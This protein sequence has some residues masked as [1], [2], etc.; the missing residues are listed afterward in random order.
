M[1]RSILVLALFFL[2]FSSRAQ[3]DYEILYKINVENRPVQLDK[4]FQFIS[5]ST[6]AIAVGV[7][8]VLLGTG[9]FTHNQA[10]LKQGTE[11][12][13]SFAVASVLSFGLKNTIRRTRPFDQH[14]DIIKLSEGGGYSFPS[15]HTSD[16]FALATS[17]ALNNRKWYIIAPAY[18]WAT[19]VAYSRLDLG[20][21]Y[22]SDVLGGIA[23]G[24][25]S[26]YTARKINK[27][28]HKEKHPNPT[29]MLY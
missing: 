11:A 23:V 5:N 12:G 13:I 8:L 21:H 20:V 16:A 29:S 10:L 15:G 24:V 4:S 25:I 18:T 3:L 27:W 6:G 2:V 14:P 1:K 19:L 22:P 7:P 9:I 26:A 28:I 17:L